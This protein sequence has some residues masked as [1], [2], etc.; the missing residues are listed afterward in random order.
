MRK[1]LGVIFVLAFSALPALAQNNQCA[2]YQLDQQVAKE[3]GGFAGDKQ[4][5]STLFNAERIRLGKNFEPELL[6]YLGSDVDRHYWISAFLEVPSYLH[7][8]QPLRHL[9]LLIKQ[10]GLS[11]LRGQ[12]DQ[13]SLGSVVSLSVTAAVL[14]EDLGLHSL[15]AAYKADA[16][17]LIAA[18]EDFGGWFPAMDDYGRCLYTTIGTNKRCT[19]TADEEPAKAVIKRR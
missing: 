2:F 13:E 3:P 8:N 1:L 16:E 17:K 9:S 6:Q 11:L 7:G 10:Q 14:S 5:L 18:D 4:K 19:K 15:A 12:T